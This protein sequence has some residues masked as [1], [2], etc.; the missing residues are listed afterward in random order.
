MLIF[1]KTALPSQSPSFQLL[2]FAQHYE[3]LY[4]IALHQEGKSNF[5]IAEIVDFKVSSKITP[6]TILQS[7][8]PTVLLTYEF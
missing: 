2:C 7:G 4:F 5:I 8:L 6:A 3:A 1:T